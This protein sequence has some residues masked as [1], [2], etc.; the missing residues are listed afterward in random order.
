MPLFHPRVIEKHIKYSYVMP[1]KHDAIL[2][3]WAQGLSQGKFNQETQHD[4]EFIQ[5]ILIDVLGYKGSNS[6]NEWTVSKNQAVGVGNVDTALGFFRSKDDYEIIAPF[7]LK[8]AKT[9]DLDANMPGRNKSPVQQAWEYAMDAKGAKW[10]LVSNYR[11]IR[12]Y[13]V[14]YGRKDYESFDLTKLDQHKNYAR[15]MLLLSAENLLGNRTFDLLKESESKDKEITDKFYADYKTLR[16]R[17][18][19]L[20]TK[21]NPKIPSIKVIQHTQTI[22][23]RILF[24]A[25]A[26]DRGLLPKD[27]LKSCYEERAKWNPQPVWNNFKGL[28]QAIDI[29]SPPLNINGYNGGLFAENSEIDNFLVSDE[30]CEG[31]KI[32]GEYDFESDVSVNILGHIFEQSITDLEEIKASVSGEEIDTDSKK[33]KRKKDG[34]FYTPPYITRYIVEQAVGGWLND[35]KQ[36]I[37]FE[38]LPILTDKDYES[39]KITDVRKGKDKSSKVTYNAKVKKHVEAWEAYR[40]VLSGIKVLD[41]A[42]GSGAFLIEVF[43]YLYREGQIINSQLSVLNADQAQLFR[44]DKHILANNIYGVDINRESV[45]ITKLSLWLKTA[46]RG[47]KLSYLDSNIKCGNSLIDDVNVAGDLAFKWEKEFSDIIR[48]GRFDVVVGNPPY[49]FSRDNMSISQK[50]YFYENYLNTQFKLNTYVLFIEKA[51]TLIGANGRCG[52]IIPNNF[53]TLEYNS[54]LRKFILTQT[55][56][57]HI[58]FLDPNV[59]NSAAVD[60]VTLI[61]NKSGKEQIAFEYLKFNG[62]HSSEIHSSSLFLE[63]EGYIFSPGGHDESFKNIA[64]KI[65]KISKPLEQ[66]AEVKNGV[67]AYT[68]GEGNPVQTKQMKTDRVYHSNTKHDTDWHKY[69][70]GADVDR[71]RAYWSGQYIKY[72]DNLSRMRKPDL[73]VGARILVRQIPSK[74]PHCILSCYFEDQIINDNNSMIIKSPTGD[75]SIKFILAILNSKAISFWFINHFGKMQRKVFPQFKI[76]ELRQFPIPIMPKQ[77]QKPYIDK[78]EIMLATNMELGKLSSKF[79]ALLKSEFKL[80]KPSTKLEQWYMLTF[81]EFM[82][83]LAKKKVR[84][85]TLGKRAEWLDYFEKQKAIAAALKATIDTTDCEID[86]MVYELYGLTSEEIAIVETSK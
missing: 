64:E 26:E 12:L 68:V 58:G 53:L 5:H 62:S 52:Y 36:E 30:L 78:V 77:K 44:W 81:N 41:P 39:I 69:L 8:G 70:D 37:G 55:F 31:F 82:D 80:E 20:L 85:P 75:C 47:E 74:P 16:A 57:V 86:Q 14:G 56:N 67:Q 10:V 83:E 4:G 48:N 23:D 27:T 7:E 15:F 50:N 79:L 61:F 60:N 17:M 25:F 3:S 49:I 29:G 73:F 33:S 76:N 18:I 32:I 21:D 63:K 43:D 51:H 59:F 22:L 19:D 35:R 11:E 2:K 9:R 66:Y 13:A 65:I 46:N 38:T 34:V 6:G 72:G 54:D 42:C 40:T 24:V 71:Y 84:V 28:F 1:E 45:E